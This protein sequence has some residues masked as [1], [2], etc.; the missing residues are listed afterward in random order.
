MLN[1]AAIVTMELTFEK[2]VDLTSNLS[3]ALD[4]TIKVLAKS[5]SR[6]VHDSVYEAEKSLFKKIEVT[7]TTVLSEPLERILIGFIQTLFP[8]DT[9]AEQTRLKAAE[10]ATSIAPVTRK[11]QQLRA[12]LI[13]EINEARAHERSASV[14]VLLDSVE[15]ST[16]T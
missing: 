11:S 1:L 14:K 10:T 6:I 4:L 9:H 3:R 7:E 8:R 16:A 12:A 15:K 13:G 5:G 2:S